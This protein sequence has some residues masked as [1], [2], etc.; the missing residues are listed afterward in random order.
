MITSVKER[1]LPLRLGKFPKG[2]AILA[3]REIADD[4]SRYPS[5]QMTPS[6]LSGRELSAELSA[7]MI[8]CKLRFISETNR[9]RVTDENLST[10]VI[11]VRVLP[12]VK[13]C[14]SWGH[15]RAKL[16][17]KYKDRDYVCGTCINNNNS[18]LI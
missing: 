1:R 18:N 15:A 7:D 17:Q 12:S 5:V 14:F 16:C 6:F 10:D 2:Y 13:D 9:V 8:K 3:D 11:P 4:A